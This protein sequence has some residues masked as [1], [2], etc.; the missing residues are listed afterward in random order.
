SS[1]SFGKRVLLAYL[2]VILVGGTIFCGWVPLSVNHY[3]IEFLPIPVLAWFAFRLG[4]RVTA[5]AMVLLSAIA[6]WGTLHGFGPFA[7]ETPNVGL[8]LLQAYMSVVAVTALTLAVAAVDRA[9]VGRVLEAHIA[10]HQQARDA[11][12]A[13]SRFRA[14]LES[15]PDAMV[16]TDVQGTIV[17]V[18]SRTETLFGYSRDE[19]VGRAIDFLVPNHVTPNAPDRDDMAA[20]PH[21]RAVW[22][23]LE[24]EGRRRDGSKFPVEIGLNPIEMEG[25]RLIS[26]SIRDV[27]ERK[28]VDQTVRHLAALVEASNDAI[29]SNRLDGTIASWNGGAE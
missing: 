4:R 20:V 22:A 15:A 28:R 27:S 26:A 1:W 10:D 14:L 8:V 18:N 16:I 25:E 17:L 2:L 7:G 13:E 5:T 3:P 29:F 9:R 24:R 23:G 21:G 19:L 6:I 11:L 12:R